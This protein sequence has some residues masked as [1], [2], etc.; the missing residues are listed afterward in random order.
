MVY[1]NL[2]LWR[3]KMEPTLFDGTEPNVGTLNA[4]VQEILA[5]GNWYMP[6]EICDI[7]LRK[8]HMRISDSSATARLRDARKAKFGCHVIEKRIRVGSRAY[9]YRLAR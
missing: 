1:V 8:H 4:I 9:E 6:W 7:V 2:D 3:G 5:D